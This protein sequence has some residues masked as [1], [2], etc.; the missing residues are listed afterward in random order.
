[1]ERRCQRKWQRSSGALER[2]PSALPT[3]GERTPVGWLRIAA[4]RSARALN[5]ARASAPATARSRGAPG[6][7]VGRTARAGQTGDAITL[8]QPLDVDPPRCDIGGDE[9]V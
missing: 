9:E 4:R 6:T 3:L 8:V 7:R 1:L 5:I 2:K